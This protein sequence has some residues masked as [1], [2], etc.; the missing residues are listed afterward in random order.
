MKKVLWIL[1]IIILLVFSYIFYMYKESKYY[2]KILDN[3]EQL[4]FNINNYSIFGTH[5][6]IEGCIDKKL[7]NS[8]LVLKNKEEEITLNSNFYEENNKTCFY[9]S[10]NYNEGI[11]LDELKKGNYLL[12]VKDNDLYYT[13]K[14]N[15]EYKDLEY[16]TITINNSNNKININ[17]KEY[18]NKNYV[19]FVIKKSKLP[20]DVYDISLDP[21]H[22][23]RDVGAIGTLK[24]KE[25][26]E[27]NLT[28]EVS[29]LIKKELEDMGLKVNITRDADTYLEPY[30]SGGRAI[31]ANDY[32]TKYS[33]SIHLNSDYGTMTYGGTE[34]YIPNDI[35][36]TLARLFASNLSEI[37]GYS[38]KRT[39]KKENSIYYKYFKQSDIDESNESMK[40]DGMEPYN[41]VLNS[42]YMY[43][44]REVGGIHTGAYI[45]GRNDYYGLN[46]HYNSNKTA[47]PYLLELA[48]I[49]YSND[50]KKVLNNPEL[51]SK[52]ISK[53]I[54]E[55]LK[56]S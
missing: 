46:S 50:L 35:D 3:V 43:M 53:S 33:F 52:A 9:I 40:E 41:I 34:I 15:T 8:T 38:K 32:S 36:L 20:E 1:F 24:G 12:L 26:Y 11:F 54:K 6:N 49:N 10:E 21:G 55:Y 18:N 14:N 7:N 31:I 19:N 25:Y 45:D 30:G 37:V 27:A 23:G 51:F 2:E 48:Y 47:E 4:E 29:L 56:L 28:L 42:P 5:L 17:F 16:Y 44:I 39:D 13:L 22:G